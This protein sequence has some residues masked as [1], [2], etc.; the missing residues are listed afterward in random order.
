MFVSARAIMG[1]LA[2]CARVV[3]ADGGPVTWTSPLGLP[4]LQPYQKL[5]MTNITTTTQTFHV[6]TRGWGWGG[7]SSRRAEGQVYM[8]RGKCMLGGEFEIVETE[9]VIFLCV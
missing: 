1:W 7:G 3:A 6:S 4:I 2:D 9:G 8:G 5:S